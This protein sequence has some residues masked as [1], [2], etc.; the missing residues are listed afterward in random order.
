MHKRLL[1]ACEAHHDSNRAQIE[2]YTTTIAVTGFLAYLHTHIH[3]F[4]AP[5][6]LV[7]GESVKQCNHMYIRSRLNAS[8]ACQN[9]QWCRDKVAGQGRDPQE[10]Q[11]LVQLKHGKAQ[12]HT[13][14]F[15]AGSLGASSH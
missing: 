11:S 10:K 4:H 8:F 1:R 9:H 15:H 14:L 5:S 2:Q 12:G 7:K 6:Q 3:S 13:C